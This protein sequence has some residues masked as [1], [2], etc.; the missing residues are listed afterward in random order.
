V[1]R[2]GAAGDGSGP[3]GH[4]QPVT[5]VRQ[6]A[7]VVVLAATVIGCAGGSVPSA[8]GSPGTASQV[9][10]VTLAATPSPAVGRSVT[11]AS[12]RSSEPPAV[13]VGAGDIASCRSDGDEATADLIDG[14]A[15]I[16]FTAGDNVYDDGTVKEF[17]DCYAP[18]WGR[19]FDRTLPVSGNHD[20]NTTAARGYFGYFG[21]R[22]GDPSEGWYATDVGA[23]RFYAL[24]SD[25]WAIGGCEAGSPQ[26]RWLR[27][28]LAANPRRCVVAVWHHP[29]FSSAQHGSDP[30]TADLWRALADAGAELVISGHDHDYER[31]APQDADGSPEPDGI[32][33]LVV[34]TGGR[35][36]YAFRTPVANSLVRDDTAYGVV[37]LE[38]AADGWTSTFLPAAGASFTDSSAGTCH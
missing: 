18:T 1:H 32:V 35:S 9:P 30:M 17:A 33:E 36:H 15:G 21:A 20:Y 11:P 29:R 37:R 23:W 22:A 3:V 5:R 38:L 4:N 25:C 6:L 10:A 14:I 26:E 31:F 19:F 12:T 27:E 24:N 8:T 7:T 13:L 28:D 2:R 34:G 16:V